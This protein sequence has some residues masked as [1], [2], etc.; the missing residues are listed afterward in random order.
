M[1]ALGAQRREVLTM[2]LREG[3]ALV[4]A[5]L[6]LGIVMAAL[7]AQ[8]IKGLL[9]GVDRYDPLTMIVVGLVMIAVTIGACLLPARRAASVDP[10]LALRCG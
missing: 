8:S 1:M 3:L 9:F 6:G 5:G 7:F 4:A 10:M 2:V